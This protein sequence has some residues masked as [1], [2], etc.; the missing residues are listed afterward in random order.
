MASILLAEDDQNLAAQIRD[1]LDVLNHPVLVTVENTDGAVALTKRLRPELILMDIALT[2]TLDSVHAAHAIQ[3]HGPVPVIFLTASHDE[4]TRKRA[5]KAHP[6]GFLLRPFD[7]RDLDSAIRLAL[8]RAEYQLTLSEQNRLVSTVLRSIGDAVIATDA[9]GRVTM[10]NP[11]AAT[12]LGLP[13]GACVG[14]PVT[15]LFTLTHPPGPNAAPAPEAVLRTHAGVDV[16]VDE[17]TTP[18]TTEEGR[19]GSEALHLPPAG[20]GDGRRNLRGQ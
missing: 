7:T 2:G 16:P 12:L 19:N 10:V 8:V 11:S 14:Q 18:I 13:P 5:L 20:A 3:E 15:S 6:F 9:T 4:D 1:C 17:I